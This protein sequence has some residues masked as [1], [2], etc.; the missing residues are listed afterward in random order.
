[1]LED[2]PGAIGT[3]YNAYK[4]YRW[5]DPYLRLIASISDR[6]RLAIDVGAHRGDY[7]F[8]MRRHAAACIAFECNPAL[9]DLLRRRFDH[10]VDIRSDA[11]SE[12]EGTTVLR[13]PRAQT[14]NGLGRATIEARNAL[15]D[16]SEVDLLTVHTVRL[17]DVIDRP[18]GLIKIDVEGHEMAVLRGAARILQDDRPNLLL[19]IEERHAPGCVALAFAFLDK[20]GYRGAYLRN[21]VLVPVQIGDVS[22]QG[23]WNYVF[24]YAG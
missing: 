10:S 20:L 16:F 24:T 17:D 12:R 8:F 6:S 23:L 1:M 11:V 5:G 22:S 15:N 13:I 7:T 18:V 14:G 21:G 2:A 9:V 4:T 3:Y 19:E